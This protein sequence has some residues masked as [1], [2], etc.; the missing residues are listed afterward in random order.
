V[1]TRT[2]P[3]PSVLVRLGSWLSVSCSPSLVDVV[4]S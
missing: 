2:R 3:L 1:L 4:H